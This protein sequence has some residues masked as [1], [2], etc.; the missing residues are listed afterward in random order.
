V[1][2]LDTLKVAGITPSQQITKLTQEQ[3]ELLLSAVQKK[4]NLWKK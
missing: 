2:T 3:L 4:L 1:I